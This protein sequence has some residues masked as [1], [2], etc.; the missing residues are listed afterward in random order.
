MKI[1][2]AKTEQPEKSHNPFPIPNHITPNSIKSF[3]SCFDNFCSS[4]NKTI[5]LRNSALILDQLGTLC[6]YYHGCFCTFP[7]HHCFCI[8]VTP[9][10]S[11]LLKVLLHRGKLLR[12]PYDAMGKQCLVLPCMH[13]HL[14]A[15]A[16]H[17]NSL[18]LNS[19]ISHHNI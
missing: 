13:I 7:I 15:T 16:G 10:L 3:L 17:W 18:H 1:F 12:I 14:Q 5:V 8:L 6:L 11:T 2:G 9:L 4:F 19:S